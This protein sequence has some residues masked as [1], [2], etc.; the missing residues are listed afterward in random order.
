MG[1]HSYGRTMIREARTRQLNACPGQQK[2]RK[3]SIDSVQAPT[4]HALQRSMSD[5][6]RP[7]LDDVTG[8]GWQLS[9]PQHDGVAASGPGGN[10][11]IHSAHK[12]LTAGAGER[13]L[14]LTCCAVSLGCV[15]GLRDKLGF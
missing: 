2:G 9:A 10:L 5:P 7:G 1:R 14:R 8:P 11:D 12:L 3:T 4:N 13:F 6:A 15:G